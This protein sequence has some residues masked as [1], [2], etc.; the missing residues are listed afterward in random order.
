MPTYEVIG[1]ARTSFTHRF[2]AE[3][4]DDAQMYTE[5]MSMYDVKESEIEDEA[6]DFDKITEVDPV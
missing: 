6:I 4:E 1:E 5:Q 2:E 3:D